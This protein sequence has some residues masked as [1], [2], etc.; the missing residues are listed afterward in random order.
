MVFLELRAL[1]L[2]LPIKPALL[3]MRLEN[4]TT[5]TQ[6]HNKKEIKEDLKTF[7]LFI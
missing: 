3:S 7:C 1:L 5:I 4:C 2:Q 6:C